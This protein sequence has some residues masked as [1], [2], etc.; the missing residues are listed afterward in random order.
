MRNSMAIKFITLGL[1]LVF[2][3]Q[4]IAADTHDGK[5]AEQISNLAQSVVELRKEIGQL[6]DKLSVIEK[7][8]STLLWS[9]QKGANP[10]N[11]TNEDKS[12]RRYNLPSNIQ[13]GTHKHTRARVKPLNLTPLNKNTAQA[14]EAKNTK[15]ARENDTRNRI[16]EL[17]DS[18]ILLQPLGTVGN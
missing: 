3:F 9:G 5:L 16:N 1:A 15:A 18:G 13:N 17:L 10:Y 2:P 14:V 8:N 4:A 12:T 6:N 7:S 11:R